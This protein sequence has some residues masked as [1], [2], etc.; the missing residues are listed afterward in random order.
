VTT[1]VDDYIVAAGLAHMYKLP[2]NISTL[3]VCHHRYAAD[4]SIT[5]WINAL[6]MVFHQAMQN[7]PADAAAG[8]ANRSV[9]NRKMPTLE[10]SIRTVL[11][12]SIGTALCT[13]LPK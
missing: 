4:Y 6:N 9:S 3:A 12:L 11:D 5:W 8:N 2:Y 7:Y 1:T 10:L 13:R